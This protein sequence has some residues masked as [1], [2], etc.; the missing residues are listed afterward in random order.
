MSISRRLL[1][2]WRNLTQRARVEA[3]LDAELRAWVDLVTDQKVNAGMN[4]AEARRAALLEA[5]GVEQV[6]ESVRDVRAGN[7]VETVFRDFQFGARLLAKDRG[8][9]VTAVVMLALGIGACTA[10]FSAVHAVLVRGL[11]YTDP[12][13]LVTLYEK[14]PQENAWKHH[15]S[16]PDFLDWREQSTSFESMAAI[17]HTGVTW[18]S[19]AGAEQIM[20]SIASP[21]IFDVLGVRPM[22]GTGFRDEAELPDGYHAIILTHGFWQRRFGADPAL[23]GRTITI[24]GSARE[25]VG[26]LP[27]SFEYPVADV[28]LFAPL[29]WP[30]RDNLDRA[31]H[32]FYVVGR[33][34]P[35]MTMPAAQAE[36]DTIA[37]RL[38][39]EYPVENKGHG[40]NLISMREVLLGPVQAPLLA[41]QVAAAFVLLIA[42]ANLANLLL[43]RTLKRGQ[44]LS[45][46]LAIGA[47]RLRLF[48]Q[49]L[50][51]SLL[52]AMLGGGAGI[53]VAHAAVPLLRSLAPQDMAVPGI[54]NMEVDSAVLAA[55]LLLSISCGVIFGLAPAWRGAG[56]GVAMALKQGVA[57]GG[58]RPER[59]R[60]LLIASQIALSVMLLTGGGVFLRSFAAL[61]SVD[62][63]FQP[64]GVLTVQAALPGR[65]YQGPE[66]VVRFSSE[67]MAALR[68]LPGVE[69]I[70]LTSHLPVSGADGRTGLAMG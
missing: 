45:I 42:C 5:G 18:Q 36:M 32:E 39:Q 69:A 40:V 24:N 63:G 55:C 68:R 60:K 62:P 28:E 31:S 17:A 46:R 49:L 43:A 20:V 61:R 47:G 23:L 26:I 54:H 52:L 37:S 64:A 27:A 41:L 33:L 70:G 25:V 56:A 57:G 50:C 10:V 19:D 67:W 22:L 65:R 34:K 13:R 21:E 48:R 3:D 14:R 53:A 2:T 29:W 16:A 38:E 58:P 66:Q 59:L 8:F 7:F 15:A 30:S 9:T 4:P 11:P 6:K 1:R 51:E 44:E 35:A 12:D